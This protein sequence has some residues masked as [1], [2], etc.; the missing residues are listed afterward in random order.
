MAL[1]I[2]VLIANVSARE[3]EPRSQDWEFHAWMAKVAELAQQRGVTIE[4]TEPDFIAYWEEASGAEA[5]TPEEAIDRFEVDGE[6]ADKNGIERQT[7]FDKWW[8]EVKGVAPAYGYSIT[9][10][11]EE[12]QMEYF[13]HHRWPNDETPNEA[14]V[15]TQKYDAEKLEKKERE[16]KFF[17]LEDNAAKARG[18]TAEEAEA[19]HDWACWTRGELETPEQP[20]AMSGEEAFDAWKR[21][22]NVGADAP[23][24]CGP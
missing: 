14:I 19:F 4:D 8:E 11:D 17:E 20:H 10:A 12:S 13:W 9:E 2:A 15:A 22:G 6:L 18:L 1:V 23:D 3:P 16:A 5:V 7:K 21:D 24:D